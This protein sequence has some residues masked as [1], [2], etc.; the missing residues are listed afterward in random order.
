MLDLFTHDSCATPEEFNWSVAMFKDKG[1]T[2]VIRRANDQSLKTYYPFKRNRLGDFV[3]LWRNYL[4]I[5]FRQYITI[6]ICRSTS[7]F[8]KILSIDNQPI[9]V[10]KSMINESMKLFHLGTFDDIIFKRPFYGKGSIV[11]IINGDFSDRKV[12]LLANIPSDMSGAKK[13]P[14]SIGGWRATIEVFKLAL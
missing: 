13:V 14:I 6:N 11:T 4:F 9:L 8:I 5:E 12:E 1:A 10:R 2:Q 3:P 7:N